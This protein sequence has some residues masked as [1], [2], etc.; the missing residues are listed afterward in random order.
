MTRPEIWFRHSGA[1]Y[2]MKVVIDR[3]EGN[4]AVIEMPN[5]QF[6]NVPRQLMPEGSKEGSVISIEVDIAETE[7][8]RERT[9][10]LIKNVW[11]D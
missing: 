6:I 9:E 3:F 4:F 10:S 2:H 11:K 5:K 7:A 8:R 1:K